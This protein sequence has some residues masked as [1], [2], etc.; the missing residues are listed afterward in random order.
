[1]PLI[2]HALYKKAVEA[3]S[4]SPDF[5][6]N[7]FESGPKS[8]GYTSAAPD[9]PPHAFEGA[10]AASGLPQLGGLPPSLGPAGSTA[11]GPDLA[12]GTG[13]VPDLSAPLDPGGGSGGMADMFSRYKTPLMIGGGA[14]GLGGLL[15]YMQSQ[16]RRR[17]D[18]EEKTA[19]VATYIGRAAGANQ[20]W[21]QY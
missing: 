4:E 19:S 6:A 20:H 8:I 16:K 17:R 14:L 12:R 1:M 2:D 11:L 5:P 10:Q 15:A 13:S 21:R 9:L 18:D 7:F 3:A